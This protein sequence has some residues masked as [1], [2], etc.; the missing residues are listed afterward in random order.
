MD[1][2]TG[3]E[4]SEIVADDGHG[5][6]VPVR[7]SAFGAEPTQASMIVTTLPPRARIRRGVI[8]LA[9]CWSAAVLALFVP[10][11][12]RMLVPALLV[13]GIMIAM[14]CGWWRSRVPRVLGTCPRCLTNQQFEV[15][16]RVQPSQILCC[17]HCHTIVTV[18]DDEGPTRGEQSVT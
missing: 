8:G 18:G 10:F 16:G 9:A 11:L 1:G 15:I 7:L 5:R 12:W 3:R 14:V 13:D 4:M 17:P 2:D 6:C